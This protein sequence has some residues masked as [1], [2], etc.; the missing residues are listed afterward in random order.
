LDLFVAGAGFDAAGA[1]L[2]ARG[3]TTSPERAARRLIQGQNTF[4]R[5]DVRS[6]E[7]YAD[8]RI[9]SISLVLGFVL[10]AIAYV[11]LAHGGS[12][13]SHT[14]GAYVGLVMCGLVAV[15]IAFLIARKAR[16]WRRN[17]WLVEFARI[18]N[19]GYRHHHPSGRELFRFGQVLGIRAYQAEWGDD[20][21]YAWRVFKT[22]VR[23]PTRDH[24]VRPPNFQ[25]FAPLDNPHGYTSELPKSRWRLSWLWP[26]RKDS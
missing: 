24:E 13:L 12:Q 2:L 8:G 11:W 9:G 14:A 4:A 26:K 6:A 21:A 19:Y 5:F 18:D 22:P 17:R 10:Q 20:T 3:L 1:L 16:P 7:D 23:D 25:P 15:L